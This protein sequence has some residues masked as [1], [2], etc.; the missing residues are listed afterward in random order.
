MMSYYDLRSAMQAAT[1]FKK[2]SGSRFEVCYVQ[3]TVKVFRIFTRTTH[4]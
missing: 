2:H 3:P 1:V 4:V